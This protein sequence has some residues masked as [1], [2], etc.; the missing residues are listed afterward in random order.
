MII[1]GK[2]GNIRSYS[3]VFPLQKSICT[4]Y[5]GSYPFWGSWAGNQGTSEALANENKK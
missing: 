1:A 4:G 5:G 2:D 3:G